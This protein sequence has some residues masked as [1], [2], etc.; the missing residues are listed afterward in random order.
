MKMRVVVVPGIGGSDEDHWQSRW[1]A[2][3]VDMVRLE[4]ASWDAPEFGD[5][6][7]ALDR[8]TGGERV[9]IVAHS[10]GC[11]LAVRWAR[12]HDVAGLFLVAVPDPAGA[13]FPRVAAD[14][15]DDLVAPPGAPT[16]LIASDD[17]PYCSPERSAAFARA[18]QADLVSVGSHGHLNSASNLGPWYEGRDL[19]AGF[20]AAV[21]DP[22]H[23]ST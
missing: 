19:F 15:G 22:Q 4:P 8:A 2:D 17:D 14:F 3:S 16:L 9:V 12:E 20:I 18:W 23:P 10:L 5:W 13:A 6:S 21:S 1:E 11:L 7:A